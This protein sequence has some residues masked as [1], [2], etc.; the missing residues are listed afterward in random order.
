MKRGVGLRV[1]CLEH[2]YACLACAREGTKL[3]GVLLQG[4]GENKIEQNGNP[5]LN[6]LLYFLTSSLVH[7]HWDPYAWTEHDVSG[8]VVDQLFTVAWT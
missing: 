5:V 2:A 7:G 1:H 3:P 4:E 6:C 8:C